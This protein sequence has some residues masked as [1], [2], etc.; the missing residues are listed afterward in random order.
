MKEILLI[1]NITNFVWIFNWVQTTCIIN[2]SEENEVCMSPWICANSLILNIIR[3]GSRV[4]V[5]GI[6]TGYGLDD[7]VV[8][9][10]VG[11]SCADLFWGPPNL[12]FN[13]YRGF[14][15]RGWSER[16]VKLTTH[17][18]PV[19]RSRK[20]GC[21]HPLPYTP[22]WRSVKLVKHRDNFTF[23]H[24]TIR[25]QYYSRVYIKFK[26]SVKIGNINRFESLSIADMKHTSNSIACST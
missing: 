3:V 5:V 2:N 11:R 13:G 4:S 7:G 6:A 16:V 26:Y 15:P 18:H 10:L 9:I 19:P 23:S 20:Y 14:F 1:W 12:V 17:L 25:M 22:S 8:E 24:F 21:I